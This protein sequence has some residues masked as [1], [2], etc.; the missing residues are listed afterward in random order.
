MTDLPPIAPEASPR[1]SLRALLPLIPYALRY[2][3]LIAAA[4]AALTVASAATLTVPVAVRGMIDHGFSAAGSDLI[5]SYFLA[6]L[7]VVAVL[8]MASGARYYLVMIIGE[9]VVADLRSDV[10]AHLARLDASFYDTAR[11]GELVSRLTAD[12]TQMKSAFGSSASVA[13]RNLFMFAGAIGM[14]VYTSPKLSALVLIAIPI[15]VFPLVA[16]GRSVRRR[17]RKAQDTLAEASAFAAENLG[18]IRTMQAFNAEPATMKRFRQA[19]E[20]AYQAARNTTGARALLTTVAIF[21]AFSSVIAVL[22]LGAQDVLAGRIT[23]GLLSQFVL[24]AVFGAS[25]LGQL[26]EVWSEISAAAGAAGRIAEILAIKP[27]IAAPA[28]PEAMPQPSRGQVAFDNVRFSYP[29]RSDVEA[30]A[31]L[32]FE[33]KSGETI[34]LVGPSGAGKSTVFQLLLR[35][36]DPVSGVIRVDDV[37]VSKVDPTD[38]R[39][40]IALVPQ[41]S[42][43]FGATIADNI[44][45]G[46]ES[47][48]MEDVVAAAKRAAA[49]EFIVAMPGGYEARVGE[50]GVTLSGGQRQ[51]LAIARAILKNAPILLLDEAT[52]ALDA[53]NE[54]LVQAALEGLMGTRTTIVIAHRL[55]TVLKADRILVLDGGRIVEEGDHASLVARGGLYARLARLQFDAAA[56]VAD[57]RAAE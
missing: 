46:S 29:S 23:G 45:Y 7:A 3:G 16:S 1:P 40:R 18:A 2:R 31:G 25:S 54:T 17:S 37:D 49:D 33:V 20:E 19:V 48:P 9:R 30:L 11:T 15:I 42:V 39:A 13:L 6:M 14:M 27:K 5:S 52:S 53:E 8:A 12:T 50:R 21:L 28:R 47:A 57:V 55:A 32:S 4:L 26:S 36:Y 56:Q 35:F 24:Y 34:A 22:W 51:R 41:E 44:R 43:V 10:F 38:L